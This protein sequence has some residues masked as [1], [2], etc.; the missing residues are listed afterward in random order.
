MAEHPGLKLLEVWSPGCIM[1][2]V[3]PE[4][5]GRVVTSKEGTKFFAF[6]SLS[7]CFL[8]ME[9]REV[10]FVNIFI[11]YHL[12]L[13][14]WM[15]RDLVTVLELI[16]FYRNAQGTKAQAIGELSK[17]KGGQCGGATQLYSTLLNSTKLYSTLLNYTQLY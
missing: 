6:L 4:L 9:R 1:E 13:T 2:G 7:I 8:V 3:D 5:V 11:L 12:Y 15:L 17:E 14:W 16:L 10:F